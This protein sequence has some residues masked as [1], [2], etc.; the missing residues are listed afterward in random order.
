MSASLTNNTQEEFLALIGVFY[1]H[2][3]TVMEIRNNYKQKSFY[4]HSR[5]PQIIKFFEDQEWPLQ[6]IVD[7]FNE[8]VREERSK[9]YI[10]WQKII[11]IVN[12]VQEIE[13]ALQA[14]PRLDKVDRENMV[15]FKGYSN[16]LILGINDIMSEMDSLSTQT[17]FYNVCWNVLNIDD[18]E[19][20]VND[21]LKYHRRNSIIYEN[22]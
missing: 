12:L 1:E 5:L 8:T 21:W 3:K 6:E 7:S 10:A 17:Y 15:L 4:F 18:K 13:N 9:V 22:E 20:I 14:I 19:T 2:F 16:W 11:R